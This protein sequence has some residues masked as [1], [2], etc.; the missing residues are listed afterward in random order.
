MLN[1]CYF[2]HLSPMQLN[3]LSIN[4]SMS[5]NWVSY[6]FCYIVAHPLYVPTCTGR[7]GSVAACP[8]YKREMAG[9]IPG[10]AELCSDVVLLGKA[11]CS[12]VHSLDSGVSGY[13]VG[14]CRL[15]CL[16]S[17]CVGNGS[18]VVCFPGC[19]DGLWTN[20]S[21]DRGGLTV[22]SRVSSASR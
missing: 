1:C 16:N 2:H 11:L 8:T 7:R 21:C 5:V 14:Q 17:Y 12:H 22:W 6:V 3:T 18:R 4:S 19:W 9:S 13:L 10:W 15:V 20:R